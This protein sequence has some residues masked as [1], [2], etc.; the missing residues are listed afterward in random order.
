[1]TQVTLTLE[2]ENVESLVKELTSG[3]KATS[4]SERQRDE[5]VKK[6]RRELPYDGPKHIIGICGLPAAG[7]S[8]A[9]NILGDAFNT[10]PITMGQAIRTQFEEVQQESSY[11]SEELG[12]FAS[13]WRKDDPEAIPE[14]VLEMAQDM[15][16][17]VLVVDGVRSVEDHQVLDAAADFFY[18]I[19][20]DA[21][22]VDRLRKIRERGRED[23]GQ[24]DRVDLAK[25]DQ[26]ELQELGFAKVLDYGLPDK[27]LTHC[28][29]GKR[30]RIDLSSVAENVPM[31]VK[32]GR[33]FGLD[34]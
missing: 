2:Q 13:D 32:D 15:D 23:E 29:S 9:A 11:T 5:I 30:L 28:F 3:F 21:R 14:K 6:L 17:D 7:K 12:E 16:S 8:Y 26:R 34:G 1:M 20:I 24:F 4:L 27:K 25:R 22:F 10:K 31:R 33:P 19:H 18:L